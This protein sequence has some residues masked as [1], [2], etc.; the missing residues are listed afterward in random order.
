MQVWGFG[1]SRT[2][3]VEME[4]EIYPF[5]DEKTI[6]K[7]Q[8]EGTVVKRIPVDGIEDG[9]SG[10]V[11]MTAKIQLVRRETAVTAELSRNMV[12]KCNRPDL[13][14]AFASGEKRNCRKRGSGSL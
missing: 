3:V 1:G 13:K 10:P 11:V 7:P 14:T 4:E 12:G 2:I 5:E 6:E 9:N 8:G